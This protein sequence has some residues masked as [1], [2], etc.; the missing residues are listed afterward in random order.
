MPSSPDRAW[1]VAAVALLAAPPPAAASATRPEA[2]HT[3]GFGEPTCRACHFDN[4]QDEPR[5]AL[6]IDGVP[7]VAHSGKTYR[8]TVVLAREGLS[9]AGFQLAARFAAGPARA[10]AAGILRPVDGGVEIT[11]DVERGID[12]AHHTPSGTRAAEPGTLRWQLDWT[13]PAEAGRIL[14]HAAGN[15]TNDDDSEFGDFVYATDAAS[16]VMPNL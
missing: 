11:R 15:A 8:V 12:Y 13:A 1:I 14:F 5:G 7:A 4:A 3:G 10:R 9:R 6:R 16:D 2:G